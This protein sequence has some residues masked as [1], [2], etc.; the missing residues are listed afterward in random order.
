MCHAPVQGA[1]GG[2][3]LCRRGGDGTGVGRQ[4]TGGDQGR[5]REGRGGDGTGR[6]GRGGEG[7]PKGLMIIDYIVAKLKSENPD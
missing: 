3:A 2:R 6:E 7:R 4:G 1:S 5:G